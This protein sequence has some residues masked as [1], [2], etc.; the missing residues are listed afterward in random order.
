[1]SDKDRPRVQLSW[2]QIEAIAEVAAYLVLDGLR[3]DPT[4]WRDEQR[5]ELDGRVVRPREVKG[6]PGGR[7]FGA[8]AE[9]RLRNGREVKII[10]GDSTRLL[11]LADRR[12]GIE[13]VVYRS[14][15]RDRPEVYLDRVVPYAERTKAGAR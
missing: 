15:P 13:G 2:K 8:C 5:I 6:E 12:V 9:L 14:G 1:M 3:S 11:N 4:R 10:D 7:S